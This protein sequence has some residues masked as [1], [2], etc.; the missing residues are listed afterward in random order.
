MRKRGVILFPTSF[1]GHRNGYGSLKEFRT[2]QS[3]TS[4]LC[5]SGLHGLCH[6]YLYVNRKWC[7]IFAFLVQRV[8]HLHGSIS[9]MPAHR[10]IE[11][12]AVHSRGEERLQVYC[13]TS[14]TSQSPT[15]PPF[16]YSHHHFPSA[17]RD[18]VF[19][20]IPKAPCVPLLPL[21][22]AIMQFRNVITVTA[23]L[24]VSF[25]N[26][27]NISQSVAILNG[28]PPCTVCPTISPFDDEHPF[29]NR[30]SRTAFSATLHC[31]R[32]RSH[33]L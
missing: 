13:S 6:N 5:L 23:A 33:G 26:A 1:A 8:S 20:S 28:L 25:V 22:S 12:Y 4:S 29:T 17:T 3:I 32:T 18:A 10:K 11:M 7:Y 16:H 9:L 15:L 24:V 30:S 21:L 14:K 31:C 27:Q 2:V 19:H